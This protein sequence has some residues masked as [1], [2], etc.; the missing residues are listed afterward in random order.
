MFAAERRGVLQWGPHGDNVSSASHC[1]AHSKRS[2]N[3]DRSLLLWLL[4]H[5]S[6]ILLNDVCRHKGLNLW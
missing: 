3:G 5:L 2:I 1:L 6:L 4:T